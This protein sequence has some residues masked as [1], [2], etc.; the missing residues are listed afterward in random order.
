MNN[1]NLKPIEKLTPFTKMIMTIGTLPSSFYASMSYYESMV[2]LYEYLKNTVIPT[3]NN[4]ADA[5]EELQ[6][7][8][9]ELNEAFN[10]LQD[11][12]E[13]YF[14]NL[15]VQEEI[16][17]KLD[18][19]ALDGSLTNLIKNY[20]DPLFNDYKDGIDNIINGQNTEISNFK[21][22]V[23][24][25]IT[26]MNSAIETIDNKVESVTSGSPKGVYATVS[27]LTTAD[28][29]HDYIYVVEDDGK[30]YYYN[31]STTSWTAG[32]D[33]LSSGVAEN[34]IALSSLDRDNRYS[35]FRVTTDVTKLTWVLYAPLH[36][37]ASNLIRVRKGTELEFSSS[38]M[39]THKYTIIAYDPTQA[40]N[41][42]IL[43]S[44]RTTATY[45][46]NED[47]YIYFQ[48]YNLDNSDFA[49][50]FS[51]TN[52]DLSLTYYMDITSNNKFIN[53]DKDI[54][55]CQLNRGAY[56]N[57]NFKFHYNETRLCIPYIYKNERPI[58]IKIK[59]NSFDFGIITWTTNDMSTATFIA[60][61]GWINTDYT[62]PANT[63]FTF[64]LRK[65]DNSA[66]P[67]LLI[68]TNQ[69]N[70]NDIFEFNEY[71]N[72]T[73]L[74]NFIENVDRPAFDYQYSGEKLN[75]GNKYGF[76]IE[77]YMDV[78]TMGYTLSTQGFTV[79]ENYLV[80]LFG[81]T[82][83]EIYD[84]TTKELLG[85]SQTDISYE[86]GDCITVG[87]DKYASTDLLPLMYVSSDSTPNV[88]YVV[89]IIDVYHS[90]VVKK[91]TFPLSAG[92]F[93]GNVVDPENMILYNRAYKISSFTDP[94]NNAMICT[95]YDL[96][97]ETLVSGIEYTLEQIEQH[98][99]PFVYCEQGCNFHNGL[100][101]IVSSYAV[102]T[103]CIYVNDPKQKKIITSFTNFPTVVKN[104]EVE[105][106]AFYTSNGITK[107]I[108][109]TRTKYYELELEA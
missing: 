24:D 35:L 85:W 102:G 95:S 13:N 15:D 21:L 45:T 84:M 12:I 5:V 109:G 63:N 29:D 47:C 6:G 25:S 96:T 83:I 26:S 55:K 92:Y 75:I 90:E 20:I 3:V 106:V 103:T 22:S 88:V 108:I 59:D 52:A 105:G 16:N 37:V 99:E 50:P 94:T 104:D 78:D 34:S 40:N 60:D 30:W 73:E 56:Q 93:S 77:E 54:F 89:R 86:H 64:S 11:W 80:Q 107:M 100:I 41:V 69:L 28:P 48:L 49:Y 44:N 66:A 38:F 101:Y 98:E 39:E 51:L 23:N 87:K 31:T 65:H 19:M 70:L 97:K 57:L 62:I 9:I 74:T 27:A 67:M 7:K 33:Y 71:M 43:V 76:N 61:T 58:H 82:L 17:H 46:I 53:I 42:R 10:T 8:F 32:G 4:N 81:G 91:Y 68:Q 36:F 1:E 14:N 79:Y 18:E 72:D 2:W